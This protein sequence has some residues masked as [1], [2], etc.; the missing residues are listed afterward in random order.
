MNDLEIMNSTRNDIRSDPNSCHP[1]EN[2]KCGPSNIMD[3]LRRTP[4]LGG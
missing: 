4:G 2:P 1:K 3:I